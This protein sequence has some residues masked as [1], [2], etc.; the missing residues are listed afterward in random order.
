MHNAQCTLN[1]VLLVAVEGS[2]SDPREPVT[3][4]QPKDGEPDC[5]DGDAEQHPPTP[6]LLLTPPADAPGHMGQLIVLLFEHVGLD[7]QSSDD[8][9]GDHPPDL[10]VG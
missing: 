7:M 1:S 3:E 6:R 5:E 10:L 4:L 8:C 2:D 9:F